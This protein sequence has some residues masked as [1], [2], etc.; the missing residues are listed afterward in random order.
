MSKQFFDIL[1]PEGQKQRTNRSET[2]IAKESKSSKGKESGQKTRLFWPKR[3]FETYSQKFTSKKI[4]LPLLFLLVLA[5][6]LFFSLGKAEIEIRPK[7]ELADFEKEVTLGAD[8]TGSLESWIKENT[9]P[10]KIIEEERTLE[11]NF[12]ATGETA[13]E[14][15]AQGTIR[16]YNEYSANSQIFV[17]NTRFVSADGKLFRSTEK[18]IVPGQRYEGGKLKAG[19]VDVRVTAAEFGEEYNIEPTTFSIP[20]LLG[21]EMYTSFYAKS[22]SSMQEGFKGRA[23]QVTEGD[24]KRSQESLK[25]E[26]FEQSLNALQKKWPYGSL[27]NNELV[28]REILEESCGARPQD[29]VESFSCTIKIH[30]KALVFK[31]EDFEKFAAN[32]LSSII[33]EGKEIKEGALDLTYSVIDKNLETGW[34]KINLVA[35]AQVYSPPDDNLLKRATAGKTENEVRILL[36]SQ[37]NI[38]DST[39]KFWPFWLNKVP[40]D[41]EKISIKTI[42]DD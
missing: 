42:L 17:E 15:R 38:E 31:K 7:I 10:A 30:T 3:L 34:A 36:E 14:R 13:V 19:F 21:T 16:V 32:I 22:F 8:F 1:P 40:N 18:T 5:V 37:P 6:P 12:S 28:S 29:T 33:Q 23:P 39:V 26:V 35:I 24:I 11:K 20:G 4:I 27:N 41:L 2:I 25:N 9:L